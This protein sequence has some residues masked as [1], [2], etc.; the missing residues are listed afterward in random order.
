[1]VLLI[2]NVFPE[3]VNALSE[4]ILNLSAYVRDC[5]AV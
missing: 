5:I 1:M 2:L 4:L 3:C